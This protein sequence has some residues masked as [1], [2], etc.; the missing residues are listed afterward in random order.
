LLTGLKEIGTGLASC[1]S[2]PVF[3][4]SPIVDVSTGKEY[5]CAGEQKRE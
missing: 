3:G 5:T 1:Q 2:T 4:I